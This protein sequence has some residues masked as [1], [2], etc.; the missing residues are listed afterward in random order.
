M[1]ERMKTLKIIKKAYR[2]TGRAL[3]RAVYKAGVKNASKHVVNVSKLNRIV[4]ENAYVV[5]LGKVLGGGSL[6]KKI[7][8]GAFSYSKAGREKINKAGGEALL[9]DQFIEKYKD[10]GGIIIVK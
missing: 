9:I 10:Q 5:V 2:E 8:V 3:W 6:T 7:H 1:M 4:P